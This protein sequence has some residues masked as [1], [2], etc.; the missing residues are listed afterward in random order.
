MGRGYKLAFWLLAFAAPS[1]AQSPPTQE[2]HQ[3]LP[4]P[5]GKTINV[6]N[7]YGNV[8][9][10]AWD[11]QDVQVDAIKR[12]KPPA[13]LASAEVTVQN[14][15]GPLCIATKYPGAKPNLKNWLG[16]TT[17]L[18]TEW[19]NISAIDPAE[20]PTTDYTLSI[21]RNAQLV[22]RV[23]TGDVDI[24][25]TTGDIMVD[26][27]SGHLTARDIAGTCKLYGSYSGVNV[28]LNSLPRDTYIES[29]V[30]PLV[31]NLSPAVSARVHAHGA[32]GVKNDF[33][34]QSR[35]REAQGSLGE[36]RVSLEVNSGGGH[37]DIHKLQ[38]P[39]PAAEK[40]SRPIRHPKLH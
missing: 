15:S 31:I 5:P 14:Q 18:C 39:P 3:T 21:P 19:Q 20:L 24:E 36:G 6:R 28:T 9:V 12:A 7:D 37:V 26:I 1:F 13:Q 8:H 25:G 34:W 17:N 10:I 38:P 22:V 27:Q 30:G 16:F 33:G 32:R 40:K 35:P 23:D 2:F 29:S 11:R 4:Q